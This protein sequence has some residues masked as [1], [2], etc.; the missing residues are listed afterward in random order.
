MNR[1]S[2]SRTKSPDSPIIKPQ[3]FATRRTIPTAGLSYTEFPGP[4]YANSPL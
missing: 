3:P 4:D 2:A 1:R